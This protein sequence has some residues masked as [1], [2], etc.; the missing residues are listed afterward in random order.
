MQ[1][2]ATSSAVNTLMTASFIISEEI[3]LLLPHRTRTSLS[4]PIFGCRPMMETLEDRQFFSAAPALAGLDVPLK[5]QS[6]TFIDKIAKNGVSSIL[7]LK[8]TS[9]S[10]Q[11]GQLVAVGQ[12]GSHTFNIPLTLTTT[13]AA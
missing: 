4:D 7:P 2:L 9:V 13:P 12:I 6:A 8:I 1:P 10:V 11:D 5:T 3:M